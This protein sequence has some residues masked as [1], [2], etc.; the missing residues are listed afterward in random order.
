MQKITLFLWFDDKAE[1]AAR[2]Y[3]SVFSNSRIGGIARYAEA[4]AKASGR[5]MGSVMTVAFQLDGQ[6]FVAL[7]GGPHFRF[8]EAVSLVVNCET[9]AE[10]DEKWEKLSAGGEPSRCGWLKDRYGL[11]W[12]IVP[13]GLGKLMQGPRADK[14][15]QAILTMDKLDLESLERAAA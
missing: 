10:V 8:T 13:A 1:E 12:Q 9:Q 11:S 14:V 3:V 6:D 2:F 5:P 15:M 4:G 7:N